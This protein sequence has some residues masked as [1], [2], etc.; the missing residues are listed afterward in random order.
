MDLASN[1]STTNLFHLDLSLHVNQNIPFPWKLHEMLGTCE[2]EGLNHI[3]SWLPDNTS[4]RVHNP[5]FFT[6]NIIGKFFKQTKYKSF[7]R[8]LNIW[9]FQRIIS[10][11]NKGGYTHKY[12]VR[13]KESLCCMMSRQKV[14]GEKPAKPR[15]Y[16]PFRV[17]TPHCGK[18]R[19]VES[20]RNKFSIGNKSLNDALAK[21]LKVNKLDLPRTG[22]SNDIITSNKYN[23]DDNALKGM[24]PFNFTTSAASNCQ[25]NVSPNPALDCNSIGLVST[26]LLDSADM[27][28]PRTVDSLPRFNLKRTISF[29]AVTGRSMA[30]I[31]AKGINDC[32]PSCHNQKRAISSPAVTDHCMS[33]GFLNSIN[34]ETTSL[35]SLQ[36]LGT[37]MALLSPNPIAPDHPLSQQPQTNKDI[38]TSSLNDT[39]SK[40]IDL[41]ENNVSVHNESQNENESL[42][43]GGR[44]FFTLGECLTRRSSLGGL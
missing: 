44:N 21:E 17:V 5:N 38:S 37:M 26:T 35:N 42:F 33:S 13:L 20:I 9:G 3:V 6:S 29:P 16:F 4:F 7:Q 19:G 27:A 10:G 15:A 2:N 8:Q 12:F 25:R 11:P 23:S 18:D 43:F 31:F 1:K 14:K 34:E 39:I 36:D 22:F 41:L 28:S 40:T 32:F 30:P 24:I